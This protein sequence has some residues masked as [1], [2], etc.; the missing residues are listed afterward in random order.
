[1]PG[2]ALNP[3][4]DAAGDCGTTVPLLF[5]TPEDATRFILHMGEQAVTVDSPINSNYHVYTNWTPVLEQRGA[6][7]PGRDP[8]KLCGYDITYRQG[9]VPGHV[10]Q[11]GA[12]GVPGDGGGPAREGTAGTHR[13]RET[14]RGPLEEQ[15]DEIVREQLSLN[16]I[17]K[18][19]PAFVELEANQRFMNA[20]YN[21]N[22]PESEADSTGAWVEPGYEDQGW[23]DIPVPGSWNHAI[24]DLWSYE[25]HGWYR[26]EVRV[27]EA[28]RGR[29]VVFASEGA[30][31]MTV[32]F[33]NGTKAGEHEGGYTPFSIPVD[34]LL[35]YGA[36]NTIAVS[37]DNIPKRERCPGG[38]FDWWN[39]GGLYRSVRLEVMHPVHFDD[40]IVVTEPGDPDST[41]SVRA[42]VLADGAEPGTLE[43]HAALR[44]AGGRIVAEAQAPVAFTDAKARPALD[45]TVTKALLWSP[46]AP[47]L[48]GLTVDL[49]DPA[50]GACR[51][52]YERRVGIRSIRVEGAKLLLNG[53]PFTVK[54]FSRYEDYVDTGRTPNEV[55]CRRDLK[56]IKDMGGNTIRCHCP[57]SPETYDLCDELG[58]FFVSELP[59]YQWG[60]P[61]A[62]RD[63]FAG[64]AGDGEGPTPRADPMAA[65]PPLHP[66]VE[67]QQRIH[68]QT[69]AR[70]RPLPRT[71]P[72]W[73]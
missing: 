66:H 52:R 65:E 26:T 18:F 58:M 43:M 7:H 28:W 24:E 12:D 49:H 55:A 42:D 21:P 44:D 67:R 56:I 30:N 32:L 41:V 64:G 72:K 46:D 23:L 63:G 45:L 17:W 25:G 3:S 57:H 38:Q 20:D 62:R 8:F 69:P 40:V 48:Y 50:T 31:Y 6:H 70:H 53:K 22:A 59:F 11:S 14:R 71:R 16:G 39:H 1:M 73:W 27:P 54:G 2:F 36:V 37:V 29:R 33:V 35:E 34:D 51:D 13:N 19:C 5:E 60:R 10:D 47:N 15:G 68:V 61:L 9:Y 4:H